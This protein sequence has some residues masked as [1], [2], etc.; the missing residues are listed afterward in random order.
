MLRRRLR[1]ARG[2]CACVLDLVTTWYLQSNVLDRCATHAPATT[3]LPPRLMTL[4][5]PVLLPLRRMIPIQLI[6][7]ASS[8]EAVGYHAAGMCC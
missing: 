7:L 3:A 1:A 6:K 4:P 8:E 2:K 5:Y